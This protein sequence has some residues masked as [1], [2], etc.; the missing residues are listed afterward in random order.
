MKKL[1]NNKLLSI[2]ILFLFLATT[3]QF[4]IPVQAAN[5]DLKVHYIDVGQA[6]SIL[7]QQ[8]NQNMLIDAGNNED[9]KLV[10]E[11]LK[12]QGVEKIDVLIGTHTDEDHI[13]GLDTVI[14]TFEIGKIYM[15]KVT[16]TTDTFKDVVLAIKA[17]DMKVSVPKVG[18]TF[19]IGNSECTIIA[20]NAETYDN[21]NNYSIVTKLKYGNN[22]FIFMGDAESIS[23]GQILQ[24]QLDISAD[25]IKIGHH[26]S[27]TSTGQKF[28]E[29]VNPEYAVIS[30]GK[31]NT[32]GHPQQ[33]TMT[34]LKSKNIPVYRTDEVGTII[35]TSDGKTIT[36]D[37]K[38]GS[39]NIGSTIKKPVGL[40]A[41]TPIKKPIIIPKKS[42]TKKIIPVVKTPT[43]KKVTPT[44]KTTSQAIFITKS[45]KKYHLG[46]CSSLSKSKI[47]TTLKDAKAQ[48]FTPCSKCHPP[49]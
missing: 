48:G 36:F 40:K 26:G 37:K 49:K 35:A 1:I 31:G 15:P 10:V 33:E 5:T 44:T 13:G 8:G 45:G 22:S 42:T 2:F 25:V 4:N 39:Y 18:E 47:A 9:D 23:E 27:K 17:K 19:K 46:N 43:V 38:V 12:N 16:K 32:Y 34:L 28:L 6:D 41:V 24:K 11:Y 20:P 7:I 29:K 3:I 30:C 21:S 14:K